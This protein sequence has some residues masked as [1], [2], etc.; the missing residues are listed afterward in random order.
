VKMGVFTLAGADW[1]EDYTRREEVLARAEI[2]RQVMVKNDSFGGLRAGTTRP[3]G[4]VLAAG[5]GVNAAAIAPDGREW[6]FGYYETFGGARTIAQEVFEAVMRAEDGRGQPTIL[7]GMLLNCLGYPTVESLLRAKVLRKIEYRRLLAACPLV[8]EAALAGDLIAK[9]IIIR[10]GEGLAEYVSAL[11]R[12]FEMR[13][14]AFDV[15]LAG[16]VFK[17][18]GPL[19]IDTITQAVKIAAPRAS[20]VRA[21]FEPVAGSLMLAFD[22][23]RIPMTAEVYANLQSTMP[24]ADFFST[25]DGAGLRSIRKEQ[26]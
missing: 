10:Q 11:V 7:T 8:F 21:T 19:L 23:C 24:G 1:A 13:E 15:V 9:Q 25:A 6:A 16:S 26:D 14:L 4:I 2:A 20:V 3:Y 17:G 22:A 18:V 12:R 5:T